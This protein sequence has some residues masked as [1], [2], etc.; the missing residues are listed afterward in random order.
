MWY[1]I[2][3]KS[4][5][6]KGR[7]IDEEIHKML[8]FEPIRYAIGAF[9]ESFSNAYFYALSK[10]TMFARFLY[11][12]KHYFLYGASLA[13]LL[14]LL[15]WLEWHF[16]VLDHAFEIYSGAIAL[17]FTGVGIWVALKLARPPA[18]AA[19]PVAPLPNGTI[20]KKEIQ[21]LGL[22]ARELEV[23]QLMAEGLSNQEIAGR[24]FLS[25]NTIKTHASNIFEKLDVRRRT[26]AVEQARKL[27]II[28]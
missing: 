4:A 12:H 26:Q 15:K 1:G 20:N 11:R 24:L 18:A 3:E 8:L 19:T 22:S 28:L 25:L 7:E 16:V 21:R 9:P 17:L 23:L 13:V 10:M 2:G 14:F 6:K 5:A 27:S